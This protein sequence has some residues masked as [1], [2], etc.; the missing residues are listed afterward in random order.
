MAPPK[1]LVTAVCVILAVP[2]SYAIY[3]TGSVFAAA[4]ALVVVGIAVPQLYAR[5][6]VPM[7]EPD[8]R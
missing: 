4:V 2:I 5:F 6:A 8:R 7:S 1:N 3:Q